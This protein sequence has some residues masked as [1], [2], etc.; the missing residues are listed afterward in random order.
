MENVDKTSVDENE[1]QV[2]FIVFFVNLMEHLEKNFDC[3]NDIQLPA[4]LN[5]FYMSLK[6]IYGFLKVQQKD[7]FF[8]FPIEDLQ[9]QED[10]IP[11]AFKNHEQTAAQYLEVYLCKDGVL[12]IRSLIP[13]NFKRK[14][15]LPTFD[16]ETFRDS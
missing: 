4:H 7:R 12:E 3:N 16:C 6:Y 8:S 5:L 13:V 14:G 15:F 11:L 1:E 10:S 9:L 2:Y